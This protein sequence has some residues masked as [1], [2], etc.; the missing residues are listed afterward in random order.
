MFV[1]TP[2]DTYSIILKLEYKS[3]AILFLSDNAWHS[4]VLS[5]VYIMCDHP[6]NLYIHF[7]YVVLHI[8]HISTK[9]SLDYHVWDTIL[10][11]FHKLHPKP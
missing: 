1:S 2:D 7:V 11:A 9:N 10:Q 5:N 4:S 6:V 8:H 3:C